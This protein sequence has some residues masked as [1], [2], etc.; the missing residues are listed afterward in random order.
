MRALIVVVVLLISY[1]FITFTMTMTYGTM[2][3]LLITT[4]GELS[5]A[6]LVMIVK[7]KMMMM[8]IMMTVAMLGTAVAKTGAE[9]MVK[10]IK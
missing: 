8:V 2:S 9:P 4:M 7:W 10:F 3:R 1:I 5:K 6:V